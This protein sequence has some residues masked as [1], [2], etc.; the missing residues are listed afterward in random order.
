MFVNNYRALHSIRGSIGLTVPPHANSPRSS[1]RPIFS[2]AVTT[3]HFR[4]VTVTH[5]VKLKK[6][7]ASDG[8]HV[9]T[10]QLA[11]NKEKR[12]HQ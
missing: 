9:A 5:R 12:A 4:I 10:R 6:K 7:K 11:W 8:F 1:Y 3:F 2:C